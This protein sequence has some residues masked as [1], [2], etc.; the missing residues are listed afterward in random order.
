MSE[1]RDVERPY[2]VDGIKEYDNP[3]PPW[4]VALFYFTIVFGVAY[5]A[6]LHLFGGETIEEELRQDRQRYAELKAER[7]EE[8]AAATEGSLA[9][10]LQ[11][12]SLVAAG[13]EVY[14]TNCAACHGNQGQGLVG[15]NL[16]DKYWIHGGAPQDI[17]HTIQ[18]GVPQKG[19]V[20]WES[21][22]GPDKIEQAA[23]YVLSLG[24]T[25]PPNPKP[26]EGDVY[27]PEG[28]GQQGS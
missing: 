23:A 10:R 24:G 16:T 21:I 26:P 3:L 11:D 5:M 8:R 9:E 20:A 28:A 4:W 22:L 12:P 19:M 18:K 13:Q 14:Q 17:V 7:A 15:P 27:D 25:N 1:N 6:Y 2:V